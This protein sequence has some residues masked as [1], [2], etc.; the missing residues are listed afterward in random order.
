MEERNDNTEN[1]ANLQVNSPAQGTAPANSRMAPDAPTIND[2][3]ANV[4]KDDFT[5]GVA[6]TE[7]N[8]EFGDA[9]D[10]TSEK[11]GTDSRDSA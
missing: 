3:R 4:A 11:L 7:L 5:Q 6:G 8:P 10:P 1:P 9:A 2:S